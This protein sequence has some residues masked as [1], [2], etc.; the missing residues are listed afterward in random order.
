MSYVR[1]HHALVSS[2]HSSAE[3]HAPCLLRLFYGRFAYLVQ[4]Y[5]LIPTL[6]R[7][8]WGLFASNTSIMLRIQAFSTTSMAFNQYPLTSTNARA[9]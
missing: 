5:Q 1:F 3:K 7:L 6:D 4:F 8:N 2:T 9:V